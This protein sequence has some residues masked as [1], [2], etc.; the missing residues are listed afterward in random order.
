MPIGFAN[1]QLYGRAGSAAY[2]DITDIP[3]AGQPMFGVVR[4]DY[5]QPPACLL[6]QC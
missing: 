6:F 4:N 5:T 2:E 1:P 3:L